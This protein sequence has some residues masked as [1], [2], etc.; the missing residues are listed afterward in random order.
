MTDHDLSITRLSED[1][2]ALVRGL[3]AGDSAAIA[4]IERRYGGELRLFCRRV[5]N[6]AALA[7]DIV[8]DVLATCCRLPADSSPT[9]SVRGWLYQIVRRRCID[10][11]RR[12]L[13]AG[14]TARA[15]RG[16]QPSFE[17]A[18]DPLTTPAGRALKRDRAQKILSV[19]ADLDDEL[20][21]VVVMRYFQDL[22]REEIAE[23]IGLTLAG[24][25][26]RL[27]KAMDALRERLRASDDSAAL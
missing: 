23:A 11:Q 6:D 19:L 13:E 24:A 2:T 12:R 14:L 22:S 9:R 3:R 7:E 8:Q 10:I 5:L 18:V 16:V 1:E 4:A 27:S 20:R 26:A 21:D 25:K 17:Y 15:R